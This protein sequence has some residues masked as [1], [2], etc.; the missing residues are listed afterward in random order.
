MLSNNSRS[1]RTANKFEVVNI[2][3][4][5][6]ALFGRSQTGKSTI[7]RALTDP[8]FVLRI[9]ELDTREP[10][11]KS[12]TVRNVR[13]N[14]YY[15]LNIIDTPGLKEVRIDEAERSDAELLNL[16]ERF[17]E[18]GIGEIN[19]ICFVSR[20]GETHLHDIDVFNKIMRF[21]GEDFNQISMMVLTHCDSFESQKLD[22]FENSI[23][24]HI[25][26]KETFEY[27]KLGIKRFGAVS[28]QKLDE[29]YLIAKTETM[30]DDLIEA[31]I[32]TNGSTKQIVDI[33]DICQ[34]IEDEI[35]QASDKRDN[36]IAAKEKLIM[37]LERK[38]SD[39][40]DQI[41]KFELRNKLK[42]TE[43]ELK[44]LKRGICAIL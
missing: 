31:W 30:R 37:E 24:T 27:C 44:E 18:L 5:N 2:K 40:Q 29:A 28:E 1:S 33:K 12:I 15:S 25:K 32:Q 6:V 19:V 4:I 43:Q 10:V 39:T 34:A 26:T 42:Q 35:Q 14:Q 38:L 21:L 8:S 23:K 11:C 9:R 17:L 36:E 13:D 3:P 20:A 41:E 22:E 16:F 7:A